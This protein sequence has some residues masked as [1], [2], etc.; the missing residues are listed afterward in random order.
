M[1]IS[2]DGIV[3]KM[4]ASKFPLVMEIMTKQCRCQFFETSCMYCLQKHKYLQYHLL[5]WPNYHITVSTWRL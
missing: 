2:D 5:G 3:V 4:L 1:R